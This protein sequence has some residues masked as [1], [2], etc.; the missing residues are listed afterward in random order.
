MSPEEVK[1]E[2]HKK[3]WDR[4]VAFQTRNPLH[5][6]HIELTIRAALE[7]ECNLLIHPVVG[8]TKPGDI[9]YKTRMQ[10]YDVAKDIYPSHNIKAMLSTIPLSMRMAGPRECMLHALIRKN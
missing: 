9:D 5:Y 3:G 8:P 7:Y 2:L 1:L 10:C 4:V 6:A